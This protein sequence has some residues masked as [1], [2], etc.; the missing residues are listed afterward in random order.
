MSHCYLQGNESLDMVWSSLTAVDCYMS[1][2]SCA[3]Q[4]GYDD[5]CSFMLVL[6]EY[7]QRRKGSRSLANNV[8]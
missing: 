3:P 2:A 4:V 8:L 1:I 6:Y 5:Y 7:Q